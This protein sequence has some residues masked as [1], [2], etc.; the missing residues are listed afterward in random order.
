MIMKRMLLMINSGK[1]N[2][3]SKDEVENLSYYCEKTINESN[4]YALLIFY[5]NEHIRFSFNWEQ[6]TCEPFDFKFKLSEIK[7]EIDFK[8]NLFVNGG[9]SKHKDVVSDVWEIISFFNKL[10]LSQ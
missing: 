6:A 1:I 3:I 7:K 5:S 9:A 4:L 10:K 2:R 8:S